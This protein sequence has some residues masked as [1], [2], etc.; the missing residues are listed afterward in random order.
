[1]KLR[2]M[3]DRQELFN[4]NWINR[5]KAEKDLSSSWAWANDVLE[6]IPG[7][8][9]TYLLKIR[10]WFNKFPFVALSQSKHMRKGLESLSTEDHLGAV[11]ELFW[12]NTAKFLK[13][14][15]KPF[16]KI[17][18]EESS[19][20]FKVTSPSCFYCEVT[21]LNISQSDRIVLANNNG[22]RL[23]HQREIV[24]ILQKAVKEKIKQLRFGYNVQKPS[25]LVVFD[26][27]TFSG[28][29]T[30]RPG[31]LAEVLLNSLVGLQ[32][33]PKELSTLLYLERYVSKGLFRLRISQSAVY[34]NPLADYQIKK[35][36][37]I[38]IKQ[39]AISGA[40]EIPPQLSL[41]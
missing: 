19:P 1:M 36:T 29:E 27:S 37:F 10:E 7:D 28:F 6:D 39:F 18:K 23:N 2:F 11:N 33:M 26:Y 5:T 20:D 9:N 4:S 34:H 38:W 41:D 35:D 40:S 30:D 13:W 14:S 15:L 3:S 17:K 22:V 12:Y 32:A 21:T 31:A 25:V 16:F 8:G 24:R